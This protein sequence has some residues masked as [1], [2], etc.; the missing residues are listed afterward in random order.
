MNDVRDHWKRRFTK[1]LVIEVAKLFNVEVT[2][3]QISTSHRLALPRNRHDSD[4][5]KTSR[6]PPLIVRF[7]IRD[8]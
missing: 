7:V 6:S 1:K 3:D 8:V 5:S 4:L 2:P